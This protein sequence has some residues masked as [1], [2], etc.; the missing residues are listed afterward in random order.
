M[1]ELDVNT[2]S[3]EHG[4]DSATVAKRQQE[5]GL[6]A[7]RE[8]GVRPSIVFGRQFK[9]PLLLLLLAAATL[10]ITVRSAADAVIIF[11]IVGLSVV[12]GFINEY[13]SEEAVAALHDSLRHSAL[14]T[15]DGT[16]Q[17]IDVVQLVRGDV[18]HLAMGELVPADVLISASEGLR[19]DE[20]VITG[21]SLAVTKPR[22][23]RAL[24]GS[25][26]HAGT[27]VGIVVDT[28]VNSTFGDIASQLSQG[29]S[30]TAFE[31]GLADFARFLVR[32][33]AVLCVL[34]FVVNGI[35]KHNIIEGL[36]FALAIAIGITPQL[37][38][39]IVTVT[40]SK[41]AKVLASKRVLV[42]RLVAIEDLGNID[43][44]FTDK[45]GTLTE[46]N[47]GYDRC[48]DAAGNEA[49]ELLRLGL[50]CNEATL[51]QGRVVQ[52]NALDSAL[53]SYAFEHHL[54]L[55]NDL[56]IATLPFDH[57]R[58]MCSV[59][60]RRG[61]SVDMIT[62]G[63]PESV[64][65]RCVDMPVATNQTLDRLYG[66]GSRVI[67]VARRV[68]FT[69]REIVIDDERDLELCGFICFVDAPKTDIG[70]CIERLHGL[71]VEVKVITGDSAIVAERVCDQIG[72]ADG[73]TVQG[74]DLDAMTD[75]EL[76]K[77]IVGTRIFARV[78]PSQKARIVD[79]A[80]SLGDDVA[81]LGDGVNDA[82]ALHKADVGISVEGATDIATDAADVV[83]LEKDLGV[84][85]D[86]IAEGRRTFTNTIK[87]VLMAT[88]SN[89]GNMFSASGASLFLSFLPMLPGQ[90]LL[91]NLLYDTS[92]MTIPTDNVDEEQLAKPS[93]WDIGFIR[94]FMA[95][96]GTISSLFDFATF[97]IMIWVLHAGATE[98]RSGWFMESLC[99]QTLIIFVIRTRRS[100]FWRSGPSRSL[101]IATIV[102]AMA[103]VLIPY[104]PFA[105][106]LGFAGLP[107][108]WLGVLT[109]IVVTYFA[110]CEWVKTRFYRLGPVDKK[111]LAAPESG[112]VRKVG[113]RSSK[114]SVRR[115]S[116][117]H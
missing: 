1:D 78:D 53:W 16:K 91:N 28:V 45:T 19:C 6:N 60:V 4:L 75:G 69:S 84:L 67:A 22:G 114:F 24:S 88:S 102:C 18:V 61:S 34:V 46:G 10:S 14:V 93:S 40:L 30:R 55:E 85:A 32:V 39:A 57:D 2:T 42:K 82:I 81:Y 62:K 83:L 36:L 115:T 100:P 111:R 99:T 76:G 17:R 20:S 3:L 35:F 26:V 79:I 21:E 87:Y 116:H 38:P 29:R 106:A 41:G 31:R 52:G 113:S 97:G 50:M 90:I 23:S 66:E 27:G 108:G 43:V 47:I 96:F 51:E 58:R 49:P 112:H 5:D 54:S 70:H 103:G 8:H 37:L 95:V 71:G 86:G 98:F 105:P 65:S 7:I 117:L 25:V 94:R 101:L 44:L 92:Q 48:I 109:L 77:A 80:R 104:S 89:F 63:A 9:N 107:L 15:R 59:L 68:D 64:L 74:Q 33:A 110:V 13:R 11:V 56:R 72:L 12:L 73:A